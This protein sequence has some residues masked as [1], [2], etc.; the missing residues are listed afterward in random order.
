V[1]LLVALILP[2]FSGAAGLFGQGPRW[3]ARRALRRRPGSQRTATDLPR[4]AEQKN[5]GLVSTGAVGVG[6]HARDT[7]MHAAHSACSA[8]GG[9]I[10][11]LRAL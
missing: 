10:L 1:D 11:R 8:T 3:E 5:C 9:A 4:G 2:H 7:R 6:L